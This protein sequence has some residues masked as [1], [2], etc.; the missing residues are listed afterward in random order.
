M[1]FIWDEKKAARNKQK[2]KVDFPTATM[3]F[4]DPG[5]IE[6][7][8]GVH[9]VHEERWLTIGLVQEGVLFVVYT[10]RD[11]VTRIISARKANKDEQEKYYTI[12]SRS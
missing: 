8:D 10:E 12:H 2:H 3:V 11:D 6:E 5:R 7:Y 1:N 9:S 4:L